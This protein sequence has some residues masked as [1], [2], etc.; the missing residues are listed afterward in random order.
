MAKAAKSKGIRALNAGVFVDVFESRAIVCM[1]LPFSVSSC[2]FRGTKCD[3]CSRIKDPQPEVGN[4]IAPSTKVSSAGS[5]NTHLPDWFAESTLSN[6]GRESR[7]Y[8]EPKF[9]K[10]E[11]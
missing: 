5:A 1:L 2:S 9:V 11:L 8:N 3:H 4:A 7:V 6:R 10:Q